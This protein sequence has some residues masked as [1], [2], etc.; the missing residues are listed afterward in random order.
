MV[1]YN[2]RF[3]TSSPDRYGLLKQYARENRKNMALAERVLW[4]LLRNNQEG[5]KFYRQHII[6]DFIVDF[7]CH[8]C[9]LVIEVDGGYH[10]EPLQEMDDERRTRILQDLGYHVIRFTNEEV[11]FDTERVLEI[12]NDNL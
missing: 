1:K 11:L 8:D 9:G 6:G 5:V 7:L 3:A 4:E 10:S 12:I 2:G